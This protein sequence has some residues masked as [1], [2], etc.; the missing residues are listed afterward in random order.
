MPLIAALSIA[1]LASTPP[2]PPP[3]VIPAPV[4]KSPL[5]LLESADG[6][7]A[8][9][10][11]DIADA[12]C[13]DGALDTAGVKAVLRAMSNRPIRTA[14]QIIYRFDIDPDGRPISIESEGSP[15]MLGQD[16]PASLAASRF[17]VGQARKRCTI[18]YR[19]SAQA[20]GAAAPPD[21]LAYTMTPISGPL[22]KE[23]WARIR[24]IG[25][26]AEPPRPRPLLRAFPDFS[27]IPASPGRKDW[28]FVLYDTDAKGRPVNLKTF[29]TSGNRELDAAARDAVARSRFTGGVRTQCLYPYRRA[30]E[31]VSPPPIPDADAFRPQGAT[32]GDDRAWDRKPVLIYPAAYRR[33]AVEG[34]AVLTYDIAPWGEIGNVKV[35][36][37]QPAADFG[38]QAQ[39][40][41]LSARAAA[42]PQG[43]TGCVERV[44]FQIGTA[45]DDDDKPDSDDAT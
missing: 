28:S 17:P 14:A 40:M 27:K 9:L 4:D 15:G 24:D 26:C 2:P 20:V 12:R 13:S 34:W 45:Q 7:P 1:A 33:R 21:L 31:T 35:A 32:C 23:G 6:W 37:A 39:R 11:W 22:P 38:T 16:V 43:W 30:P 44:R 3:I 5:P 36:A 29:A 25:T 18:R 19:I 8:L 42:S 41:L 10:S